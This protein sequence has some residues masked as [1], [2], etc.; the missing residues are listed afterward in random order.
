[1]TPHRPDLSFAAATEARF[2]SIEN[3]T[4]ILDSGGLPPWMCQT[5]LASRAAASCVGKARN[6]W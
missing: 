4:T 2:S 3:G 6:C 5:G 1:M